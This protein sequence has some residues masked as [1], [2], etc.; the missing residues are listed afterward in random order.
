MTRLSSR[1][2]DSPRTPGQQRPAVD[3][4]TSP[5]RGF[6]PHTTAVLQAVLV[7]VLWSSSYVLIKIGLADIPAL[8]F[9]GLRYGIAAALLLVLFVSRGQHRAL[10]GL[11]RRELGL[12]VALG[13]FLYAVTQGAQFVALQYL[14]AATISLVLSFTPAVVALCAV[15]AL[16]ERPSRRQWAWIGV[17]LCGVGVYFHPF[18]FRTAAVAGLAVMALG[19]LANAFGAVLG[20]RVNRH[21]TLPP[22]AVTAV[23]MSVGAALLLAA[24]VALQ[25]LPALGVRNW[26][27]VLWLAVV[28]TAFAFT[29]WNRTLQTLSATESSVVNNTMLVQIAVLGWVFLGE[30][31][32]PLDVVGLGVV[33]VG[34]MAVQ[35]S[36]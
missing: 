19:V 33:T 22:L 13:V 35:R 10:R 31:L 2:D 12:L 16:G 24:G 29:L 3:E 6:S 8:T 7:T 17:L 5:S 18:D 11:P 20:R 30:S 15:P 1:M 4:K 21:R 28:N 36:T 27:I 14:R 23:S 34:A 32:T 25:G 26:A 9:A